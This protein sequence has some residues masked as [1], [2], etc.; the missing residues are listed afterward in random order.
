MN[1][2]LRSVLLWTLLALGWSSL[3]S[4]N[5]CVNFDLPDHADYRF[6][7]NIKVTAHDGISLDANLFIPNTPPPA[8]GYPTVIFI[9]SWVLDEHEYFLQAAKYAERGYQALSYSSR[10]WGCSEGMVDV[11]GPNDM[12]DLSAMVDWLLANTQADPNAIGVTG[13][14][15]GSGIS[16]LGLAHEPRIKTAV[17]MSTWGD[18]VESL[19]AQQTPRLF[20]GFFLVSSGLITANMDPA[21]AQKYRNLVEHKNIPETM[22][23][24]YERS[25]SR[26]VDQ[27][28]AR[29]A[30]V[31][32]A[33][34]FGDNLFQ[35]NN[36]LRFFEQ[37]SGPKRLDL[38]QGTHA[39]A[40][41]LGLLGIPN[42]TWDNASDWFDYW[43]K[44]EDTGIMARPPLTMLTDLKHKREEYAAWPIPGAQKRTLY[45]HPR[46]LLSN[47]GLSNTQYD[48][49]LPRTN[50]IYSGLDSGASTGIPLLSALL[51][52]LG[53]PVYASMP[54]INRVHGI[55]YQSGALSETLKI[56]GMAK[57]HLNIEP[58][59]N[60]VQLN[61]Y[62]YDVDVLSV[63]KLI[64]HAPATLHD[65]APWRDQSLDMELTAAAY[66][67]PA[68][69]RIAI[70]FDTFDILYGPP[71][72]TPYAVSFRHSSAAQS[73]LELPEAP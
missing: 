26:V 47:G 17:A 56:R 45:M 25:P 43:L 15:Y 38:N 52:G 29:Q 19:Y 6:N 20:W 41:G 5:I 34:S 73:Y 64:T 3:A 12:A 10:G 1:V 7:D 28:N 31:Y 35:P 8:S 33:N 46:G 2:T 44:G 11:A 55:V 67:V 53:L 68:G 18:L 24:G 37:L 51:D 36:L 54:L 39:S 62:L 16:L 65:A 40:E 63:G 70:A 61:A 23:W 59:Y 57:I 9:N 69:H 42:Y 49:W 60:K 22:A 32:L 66:D 21:I 13:I 4:A 27:I 50:T 71:T 14:S 30:P 48:S 58:S 72:L